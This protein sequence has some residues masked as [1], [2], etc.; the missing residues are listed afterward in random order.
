MMAIAVLKYLCRSKYEYIKFNY[1]EQCMYLSVGR[2][3]T[4]M[5]KKYIWCVALSKSVKN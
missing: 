2:S 3:N 1:L 4:M 5:H